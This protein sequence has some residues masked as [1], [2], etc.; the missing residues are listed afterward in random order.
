S[1]GTRLDAAGVKRLELQGFKAIIQLTKETHSDRM[2]ARRDGLNYLWLPI[3]DNAAPPDYSMVKKMLVF[4]SQPK[5]QPAYIHCE[6]GK[7]RTGFMVAAYQ[8]TMGG[9]TTSEALAEA[10]TYGLVVRSQVLFI[11]KLGRDLARI[12]AA[13][14]TDQRPG[15]AW[16]YLPG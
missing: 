10:R 2:P 5:N 15:P 3:L 14:A 11:R 6:A 1:R 13:Q 4:L 12:R 9:K 7:G 16:Q 8:M